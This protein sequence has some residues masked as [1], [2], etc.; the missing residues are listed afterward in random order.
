MSVDVYFVVR[1]PPEL[2]VDVDL[3]GTHWPIPLAGAQCTLRLPQGSPG[4]RVDSEHL[5]DP[6]TAYL[7]PPTCLHPPD[8]SDLTPPADEVEGWLRVDEPHHDPRWGTMRAY[9]ADD[10]DNRVA[11]AEVAGAIVTCPYEGDKTDEA[12]A[13][14]FVRVGGEAG[15]WLDL[16][17]DW[18]EVLRP[19]VFRHPLGPTRLGGLAD[20][21][22]VLSPTLQPGSKQGPAGEVRWITRQ[23]LG[24]S[25]SVG[26]WKRAASLADQRQPPPLAHLFLRDAR[27]AQWEEDFRRAVIDA[28]TSCEVALAESIRAHLA[29]SPSPVDVEAIIKRR[30]GG[31]MELYDFRAAAVGSV[32]VSWERLNDRLAGLRNDV[33]HNKAHP[34]T[35]EE[36]NAAIEVAA[37][38][39]GEVAPL[40]VP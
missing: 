32:A 3:L 40:P 29:A 1:L 6:L 28:A 19:T 39:V 36:V 4:Y 31:L 17:T 9:I 20:R 34:P 22:F 26:L 16:L 25:L 13:E 15:A 21:W 7:H 35:A 18:L 24:H 5:H 30:K 38:L 11:R 8:C 12:R 27:R 37:A 10:D 33:V 2:V 23:Q 14:F